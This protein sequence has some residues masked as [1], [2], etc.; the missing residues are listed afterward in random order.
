VVL[1]VAVAYGISWAW[2]V[3]AL[4]WVDLG[5]GRLSGAGTD[6]G[7]GLRQAVV[8]V[9]DVGPLLAAV[10]VRLWVTREGVRGTLGFRRPWRCYGAAVALPVVFYGVL[11]VAVLAMGLGRFAWAS[12]DTPFPAYLVVQLPIM[13][14]VIALFV[15]GEEYGW[16][17]WLLPR[18][19]VWG[20]GKATLVVA[21][22]WYFWH[23]PLLVMGV[24]ADG[25][26]WWVRMP[27]FLLATVAVSFPFT[28]L[29]TWSRGSVVV[30]SLFHGFVNAWGDGLLS[31]LVVG[32]APMWLVGQT[33]LLP[34]LVLLAVCVVVYGT[35]WRKWR[36]SP[37]GGSE[38]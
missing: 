18:L 31:P 24:D 30:V 16:R 11:L 23:V 29:F 32:G 35:G 10:A 38:P 5:G 21:V 7:Q 28:W 19:A 1:F 9:G 13:G 17:G 22:V 2:W 4:G 12:D 33:G 27:L 25:G 26:P 34:A 6:S 3:V 15:L 8:A 37:V 36:G 14:L 20:E